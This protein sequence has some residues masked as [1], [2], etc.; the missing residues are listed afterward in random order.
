MPNIIINSDT[1]NLKDVFKTLIPETT[2]M[3]Y[4]IGYFY[5]S[6][7]PELYDELIQKEDLK[8][9]ILVGLKTDSIISSNL[10]SFYDNDREEYI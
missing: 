9:K 4:L 6:A 2:E 8:I 5:F 3:K 1:S 10:T 7:V